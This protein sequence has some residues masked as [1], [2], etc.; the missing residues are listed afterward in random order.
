VVTKPGYGII[1][2]CIANDT[3][4][5]YTSRGKFREYDVLVTEMPKHLR[6]QFIE[7]ADLL[8]GRW[9][10]PLETLLS[11]PRPVRK[12]DTN[13]AEAAA[14]AILAASEA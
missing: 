9:A 13:G 4:I 11:S 6:A 1:S 12:P 3:A 2:E 5:L 7:Q 8:A 14:E 10:S